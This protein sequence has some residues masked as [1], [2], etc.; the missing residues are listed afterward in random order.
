MR[1]LVT[2]G[3]G[4]LAGHIIDQLLQR[5]H[6]VVTTTRT[7][8]KA[9][10]LLRR[11]AQ[12][13]KDVFDVVIVE[14]IAVE[15]AFDQAVVSTPPFDAVCHPT[16]PFYFDVTDIQKELLEPAIMGTIGILRSIKAHAPS[17]RR[18]VIT[19]SLASMIHPWQGDWRE[20]FWFFGGET[21]KQGK[22]GKREKGKSLSITLDLAV[23]CTSLLE[24]KR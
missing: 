8:A 14:D 15:A 1:V 22:K 24:G 16:S 9:S 18:V 7:Q 23:G 12:H 5:G 19:S 20:F 11:Y 3:S 2:G 6:S 4:Y 17:V 10:G 13:G 21:G